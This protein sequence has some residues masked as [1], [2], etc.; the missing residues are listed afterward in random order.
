MSEP[1]WIFGVQPAR[2]AIAVHGGALR[3]V[4]VERRAKDAEQLEGVARFAHDRGAPVERATRAEIDRLAQGERH[5]GVAVEAPPLRVLDDPLA[6]LEPA[7][8]LVV[9]LDEITDPQNFGAIVRSAVA[10]GATGVLWPEDKS[11]PLSA[12]MARASAGAIE[13]ARLCRVRSLPRALEALRAQCAP[14]AVVGLDMSG[15]RIDEQP[16]DGPLVLVVGSEGKGLRR[17][18]KA[19]CTQI[20]RLPM[21]GPIASLNASVAA[22]LAI[23]EASRRRGVSSAR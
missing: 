7:P 13:H 11:A 19:A 22:A 18:T 8:A 14:L 4:I 1:R 5:Q 20:V 12:A 21:R 9:A 10:L 6:L 2:E 15:A 3:R 17:A 23:Y 16:L